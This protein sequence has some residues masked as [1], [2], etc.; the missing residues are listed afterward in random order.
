MCFQYPVSIEELTNIQGV[1]TGKASRYGLPFV[2]LIANY[3]S[4]NNIERPQDITVKSLVNKSGMKVKLIQNI[5]SKLPLEDIG[6]AQG[7]NFEEVI[8]ELEVIVSSGTRVNINYHIDKILDADDQ[9]EIFDYFSSA[10]SDELTLAQE[11]FDDLYSE[12]ELRLMRI[13]FMS[14]MAN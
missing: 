10:E 1:G 8:E 14:E 11:E 6:K 4:E 5:D 2:D 13:K 9:D 7:K 3:V 12:E